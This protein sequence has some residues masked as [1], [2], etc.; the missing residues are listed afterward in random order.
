M[1]N[2]KTYSCIS[3]DKV[4]NHLEYFQVYEKPQIF[5]VWF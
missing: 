3:Y 5:Q 1:R 4:A 2:L